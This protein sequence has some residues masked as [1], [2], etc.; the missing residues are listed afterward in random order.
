MVDSRRLVT[1]ALVA[2]ILPA[3]MAIPG[4]LPSRQ[5]RQIRTG[6]DNGEGYYESGE[7][8]TDEESYSSGETDE[9]NGEDGED[10][11]VESQPTGGAMPYD[12]VMT[13]GESDPNAGATFD[14]NPDPSV[15]GPQVA[16]D[17]P[18]LSPAP[19]VTGEADYTRTP[20]VA[21]SS[22]TSA[23]TKADRVETLPPP[24][25]SAAPKAAGK[26]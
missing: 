15:G 24:T 8:G 17:P 26:P 16:W 10:E 19:E 1:L 5:V 14:W 3:A 9:Y 6:N 23:D 18:A 2:V 21:W 4:P 11:Y 22:G 12:G 13:D 25:V 7:T 20:V